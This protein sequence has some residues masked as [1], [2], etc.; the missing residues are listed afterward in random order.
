MGL[1]IAVVAV[2]EDVVATILREYLATVARAIEVV[3][4]L[5][6]DDWCGIPLDHRVA[7][8]VTKLPCQST[9]APNHQP[10]GVILVPTS[11]RKEIPITVATME[12]APLKDLR[13]RA[14]LLVGQPRHMCISRTPLYAKSVAC[15]LH[16]VHLAYATEEEPH[17]FA[18]LVDHHLGV[19]GVDDA[20]VGAAC[21][22]SVKLE[23]VGLNLPQHT[24]TTLFCAV[25]E[26][27]VEQS[28]SVDSHHIRCPKVACHIAHLTPRIFVDDRL[29]FHL[30]VEEIVAYERATQTCAD[31]VVAAILALPDGGVGPTALRDGVDNLL[32]LR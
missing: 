7:I 11:T 6:C 20:S 10:I 29:V 23:S 14:I 8:A 27:D 31:G 13:A 21:D 32:R 25:V 9:T 4:L 24:Y 1:D 2:V 28:Y 17:S 22:D 5:A 26:R 15:E 12:V 3:A 18:S 19:D 30:P 16:A